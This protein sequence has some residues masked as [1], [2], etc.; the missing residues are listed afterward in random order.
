M[1]SQFSSKILLFGEYSIIKGSK[2]LAIPF[3]RFHGELSKVH[4]KEGL[5]KELQL[6]ELFNYIKGSG[7]LSK[8]LDMKS[9]EQDV[10]DGL[11]FKSNI[12]LGHG[13]GS[14]G[15][16]CASLFHRY[17]YDFDRK[18]S[19]SEEELKYLQ[20]LMA[21][22]ESFY[23]GSSSGFDCLISL[24][25]RPVMIESRN[26]VKEVSTPSLK[27]LGNFYLYDTGISR[28]TS[29]L[30]HSFLDDFE[31]NGSFKQAFEEFK[32]LTN[33]AIDLFLENKKEEFIDCFSAISR[34]QYLN[35]GKMIPD[36]VKSY[37]LEGLE[38]KDFFVKLCGAGGGGYFLVYSPRK[39][40]TS[41]RLIELR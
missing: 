6:Y 16:L 18:D 22:M 1:I 38:R 34:N 31:N 7:I 24:I 35:F 10:N 37:W 20:D 19:F 3:N 5:E 27:S 12:P 2:G 30:V 17:A 26:S 8:V 14:S 11:F 9:F 41:S 28:K 32:V 33:Q 29:P 13:V 40:L 23:H 36:S 39:V 4:E 25:N 21:L 15:A